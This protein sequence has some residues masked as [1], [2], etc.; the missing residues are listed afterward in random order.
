M[1][2][3]LSDGLISL[4]E[5]MATDFF[6]K[7]AHRPSFI[8]G[9]RVYVAAPLKGKLGKR[10]GAEYFIREVSFN[11]IEDTEGKF[12]GDLDAF[13]KRHGYDGKEPEVTIDGITVA[14]NFTNDY[15]GK[16]SLYVVRF[17]VSP[18]YFHNEGV[19]IESS[20][21]FLDNLCAEFI[22]GFITKKRVPVC[23]AA[24]Y[25]TIIIPGEGRELFGEDLERMMTDSSVSLDEK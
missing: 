19:T 6:I 8:F 2:E 24:N 20:M 15:S 22:S 1:A 9:Y 10:G 25:K 12:S 17:S 11:G 21:P 5:D 16:V 14:P 18:A 13:V 23:M 7:K 4:F 3:K